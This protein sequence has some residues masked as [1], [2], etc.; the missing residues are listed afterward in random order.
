MIKRVVLSIQAQADLAALD[1]SIA[2]RIA[3]AIH[4]FTTTGAGNVQDSMEFIRPIFVC[5]LAIGAFVFTTMVIASRSSA[6]AIAATP[7]VERQQGASA[8]I[9]LCGLVLR[10]IAV[11]SC[12]C[13]PMLLSE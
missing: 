1:R 13:S 3:G 10:Q 4:H 11:H 8:P 12:F 6:S 7:I 5:T 2:L 9:P